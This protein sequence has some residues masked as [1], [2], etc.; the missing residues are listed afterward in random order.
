MEAFALFDQANGTYLEGGSNH[1]ILFERTNN[2]LMAKIYETEKT[3]K[4]MTT[5]MWTHLDK[6]KKKA[7]M[8]WDEILEDLEKRGYR[9]SSLPQNEPDFI[10]VR[11]TDPSVEIIK[12]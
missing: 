4:S 5:R 11:L 2:P 10:A 9:K 3:A 12:K 1:A 6:F 8:E 7:G